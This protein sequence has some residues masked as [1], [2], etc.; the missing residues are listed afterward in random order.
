MSPTLG[1]QNFAAREAKMFPNKFRNNFV[2]KTMFA[3]M[4]LIF[5]AG[6]KLICSLG[7]RKTRASQCFSQKCFPVCPGL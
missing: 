6:E 3:Q 5:P 7:M 1:K 2:A 4:F